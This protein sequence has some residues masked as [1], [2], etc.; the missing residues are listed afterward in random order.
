MVKGLGPSGPQVSLKS[1]LASILR[2][3]S[4]TEFE[5]TNVLTYASPSAPIYDVELDHATAVETILR[6][7]YRFTR[8]RDPVKRPAELERV[9]VHHSVTPGTRVRISLLR[10]CF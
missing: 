4:D 9:S 2:L 8:R 3:I 5:V 7:F 6:S 1:K 10:V